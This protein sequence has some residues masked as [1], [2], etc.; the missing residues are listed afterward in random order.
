MHTDF[1]IVIA[2]GGMTG[3]SLAC[4]LSGTSMRVCVIE[5]VPFSSDNQQSFDDRGITLSPSSQRILDTLS[6]WKSVAGDASPIHMIHVSDQHHFGFV[7]MSAADLG[8]P[9]LGYVVTA[10][11][12]G[13][14]LLDRMAGCGNITLSSP[15]RVEEV[16]LH[17]EFAE[18]CVVHDNARKRLKCRLLVAADGTHSQVRNMAGIRTETRDYGQTAIVANITHQLPHKDTAFE[19][20]TVTGPLALLPLR[21]QSVLVFTVAG[22]D[23][24]C[25]MK[26]AD[27]DFLK[28]VETRFGR[29]LGR[30]QTIGKR[31]SYPLTLIETAEQVR[32]R[33][34]IL[35]NA[36]HTLHP[37]AAQGFNL[38]LRDVA[39]LA[40]II[41]QGNRDCRDPGELELLNAY[42]ALREQ[43]Q[44]RVIRFTDSLAQTFYN[45]LPLTSLLRN[46]TMLVTDL[47]PALKHRLIRKATGFW[48]VQP[49]MVRGAPL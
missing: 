9:A 2:G 13:K 17:D 21:Q 27:A 48:G 11:S 38:G 32:H 23:A 10:R 7:R 12:L 39:G 8:I 46:S 36:A 47:V 49:R 16:G 40:E 43:D 19:R 45:D 42:I 29:R 18:V 20:F 25:F 37:N 24:D 1:D 35:G 5:A 6:V 41:M 33:L 22:R 15:A 34:V 31:R 4:A 14:A 26:M 44:Q 3:A 30:L 28:N